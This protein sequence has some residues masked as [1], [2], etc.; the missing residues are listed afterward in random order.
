MLRLN[1]NPFMVRM[2]DPVEM[3][4]YV[5]PDTQSVEV[6]PCSRVYRI[7]MVFRF[8]S[9]EGDVR[10]QIRRVVLDESGIIRVEEPAVGDLMDSDRVAERTR[11][12]IR[13]FDD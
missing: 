2:D 8:R 12:Q 11:K 3:Y 6:A 1:L 9:S 7:N 13:I 4:R 5:N 10:S